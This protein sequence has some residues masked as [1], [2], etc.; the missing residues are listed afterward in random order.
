MVTKSSL[1][2]K[3][4]GAQPGNLNGSR[5]PHRAFWKR[6]VLRPEDQWVLPMVAGYE[7]GIA[8]DRGRELSFAESRV[9]DLAKTARV[10]SLLALGA[11]VEG[12][13]MCESVTTTNS[14]VAGETVTRK[15][16]V[17]HPAFQELAK[18]MRMELD[19]LRRLGLEA[20]KREPLSLK[21]YV[22]QTYPKG[23][24]P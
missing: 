8:E 16:D 12:G 11:F 7:T 10:C 1:A 22:E 4:K 9:V 21:D 20:A 24:Q 18:F 6:R 2:A 3:G 19:A 14:P 5:H 23:D 17:L 15:G 13:I